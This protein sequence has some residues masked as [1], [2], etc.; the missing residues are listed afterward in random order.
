MR[1]EAASLPCSN[2]K[3]IAAAEQRTLECIG[4]CE[5]GMLNG[6]HPVQEANHITI[7]VLKGLSS[8][9]EVVP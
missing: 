9:T 5:G 4:Q 6:V 2:V 3:P 1:A 8:E 7:F